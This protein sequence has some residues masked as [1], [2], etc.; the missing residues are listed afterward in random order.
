MCLTVA[1]EI[2]CIGPGLQLGNWEMCE[3]GKRPGSQVLNV[4]SEPERE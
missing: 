4:L 3:P 1:T 2:D